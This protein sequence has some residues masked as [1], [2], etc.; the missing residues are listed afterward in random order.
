[1]NSTAQSL[2]DFKWKNRVI[3]V[4]SENDVLAQKQLSTFK[5]DQAG[6]DDRDL[7]VFMNPVS[8]EMK[9]LKSTDHFFEVV[10]IG[11]DGTV[12]KRKDALM[13]TEELF[14]IIDGMPMRQSEMRKNDD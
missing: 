12:K 1:M 2:Y 9:D 13:T 11:K 10:L 8:Q 3:I 4:F 6:M 14:A 7:V 5:E